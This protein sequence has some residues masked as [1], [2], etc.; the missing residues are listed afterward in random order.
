MNDNKV[1]FIGLPCQVAALKNRIKNQ[2]N[3]FTIDL[4]CHGTPSPLL[5]KKYLQEQGFDINFIND[6]QFR[7][8][9]DYG[10]S[11]NNIKI[12]SPRIL[13]EYT[14]AFIKGIDYTENCYSCEYASLNRVSDLTIG[15]SW[16]TELKDEEK[17]GISLILIQNEKGKDLL[18]DTGIILKNV[19]IE[20]AILNNHQ[21]SYPSKKTMNRDKFFKL[22]SNGKTF[23]YAICSVLPKVMI[24]QK[25][26]YLLI[27]LNLI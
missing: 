25:M 21:L 18:K 11:V 16:G 14:C 20:N 24:K 5:L 26:K 10:I 7:N 2:T 22:L 13:D 6:I 27:K 8:K 15:D 23:K 3:L 12:T 1:L 4:I 9:T 17:K 19:N